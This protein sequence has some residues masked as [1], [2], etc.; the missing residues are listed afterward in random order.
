MLYDLDNNQSMGLSLV[1]YF[2][3]LTEMLHGIFTHLESQ[4][5]SQIIK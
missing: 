3:A 1:F 2:A 5:L 4:S